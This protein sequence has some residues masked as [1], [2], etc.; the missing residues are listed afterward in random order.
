MFARVAFGAKLIAGIFVLTWAL[1]LAAQGL[2]G[3]DSIQA[4]QSALRGRDF[5]QALQLLQAQ[6]RNSPRD[7]KL[8]MFQGLAYEGLGKNHEALSSFDKA[9]AIAPDYLPA[10]EGAADLEF[11]AGSPRAVPHL[12][13]IL[14]QLPDGPA[15]GGRGNSGVPAARC[16]VSR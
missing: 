11:K 6:L 10:L 15:T 1:P 16:R 8:W 12:N 4:I 13:R 3:A 2:G 5:A 14:K 7:P 9:L